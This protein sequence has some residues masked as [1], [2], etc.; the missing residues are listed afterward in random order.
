MAHELVL[1]PNY[2]LTL[3]IVPNPSKYAYFPFLQGVDEHHFLL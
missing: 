3:E 2:D 1:L